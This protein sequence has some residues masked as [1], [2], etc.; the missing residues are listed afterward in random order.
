MLSR[1]VE[2]RPIAPFDFNLLLA[3][4][5]TA[6][7]ASLEHIEDQRYR[8]AVAIGGR[9]VLLTLDA[10]GTTSD[11]SLRLEVFGPDVSTETLAA[12]AALVRRAFNLDVDP[13]PFLTHVAGDSAL[14]PRAQR[15]SA[16]RPVLLLDPFEALIWAVLGQQI[17]VGFARKLKH[18]LVN[19][20]GRRIAG[21][22]AVYELFP[23]PDA[24]AALDP[25]QLLTRQFSRAKTR[26]VLD[27]AAAVSSGDLDLNAISA[28]PQDE[29]IVELTRH[30]GIG[31]WTA[32]YLLMRVYGDPDAMP[33]GDVSLHKIIGEAVV[34][35]RV[36][37]AELRRLAEP[38]APWRGWAAFTFW[39][40][41][42]LG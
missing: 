37:E 33:A 35:H 14:G 15:W 42:Q 21:D 9:D 36:T 19:L 13:T 22:D 40:D 20:A 11:P 28:L 18:V 39:T 12:A 2:I 27:L 16:L 30:R 7:L 17:N 38:W 41:R 31:R 29:A 23:T 24:I 8:R 25:Q 5:R 6:P 34:G 32:E 10:T 3:Y 1:Q 26:Y 4:L